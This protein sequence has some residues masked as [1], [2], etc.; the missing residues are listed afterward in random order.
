[1]VK[2]DGV[3]LALTFAR[4]SF[5]FVVVDLDHS[6]REEQWVVLRQSDVILIV[7]R[8]DFSSLR[9]ARR[10]IEHLEA[11]GVGRDKLRLVV[12]RYGQPQEVPAAKAEEALGLKV[13][14]VPARGRQ[15]GQPREQPRSARGDRGAV[16]QGVARR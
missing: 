11:Q 4:A 14:A 2:P 15:G 3:G 7:L 1:M 8:L 10:A 9:N 16:G 13:A 6:F 12:N 5:P